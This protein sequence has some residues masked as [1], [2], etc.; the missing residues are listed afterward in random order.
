MNKDLRVRLCSFPLIDS[1][2]NINHDYF[3][4]VPGAHW[5]QQ[6]QDSLLA[7]IEQYGVGDYEKIK[8]LLLNKDVIEIKLRTCMLLGAHNIE[9]FNGLTDVSKIPEIKNKHLALA[10]KSGKLKYG[11]Y[12]N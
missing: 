2:G 8:D 7:G 6:D 1:Q 9:E 3:S 11:I 12:L 10:K 5:S 4:D